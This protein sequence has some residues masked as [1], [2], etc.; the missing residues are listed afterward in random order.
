MLPP[1]LT[2]TLTLTLIA[3][4]G[5]DGRITIAEDSL[6]VAAQESQVATYERVEEDANRVVN[7]MTFMKRLP[8]WVECGQGRGW[9]L[10]RGLRVRGGWGTQVARQT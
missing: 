2:L 5:A 8:K 1:L 10:G 9:G 7:S 4:V 6:T 3:Q